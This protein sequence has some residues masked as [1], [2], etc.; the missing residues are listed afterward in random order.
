TGVFLDLVAMQDYEVF[1]LVNDDEF[2]LGTVG[3]ILDLEA[4]TSLATIFADII[5]GMAFHTE[6]QTTQI[7]KIELRSPNGL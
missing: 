3:E 1:L 5:G 7:L 2:S 4:A 6:D